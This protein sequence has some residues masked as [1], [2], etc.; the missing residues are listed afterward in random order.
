VDGEDALNLFKG[1][2]DIALAILDFVMPGKNGRQVY[3]AMKAER[4]EIKVL[5]MSGHPR[6]VILDKGIEENDVDF[7]E[8]PLPPYEFLKKVEGML[9]TG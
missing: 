6:Q 5:F 7:I 3:E 2:A 8:K 4:P 9:A 1:N